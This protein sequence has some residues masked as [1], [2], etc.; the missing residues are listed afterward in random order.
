IVDHKVAVVGI[1]PVVNKD[2][3]VSN[4]SM[5]QLRDIFTGKITNWKDVGGPDM[6]ITVVNRSS[7][8]GTRTVFEDSVLK[9][10]TAVKAQ[11]Q[12]SN[13]TVQKIISSTPGSISYL[14][15]GYISGK[16]LRAVKVDNV[17]LTT[18]NIENNKWKIWGYEHMYTHGK[19]EGQTASFIKYFKSK[20]VQNGIVKELGY[21]PLAGMKVDKNSQGKV[22]SK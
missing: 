21:I 22:T 5:K 7:G 2:I 3:N 19:A 20:K 8:S 10:E 13:G 4:L 14:A 12:D 1:A 18:E 9:G 17:S 16:N 11:E 6:A 15:S